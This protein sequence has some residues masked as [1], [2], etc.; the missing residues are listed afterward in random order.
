MIDEDYEDE[1]PVYHQRTVTGGVQ[2]WRKIKVGMRAVFKDDRHWVRHKLFRTLTDAEQY[3]EL[4][5]N[6]KFGSRYQYH[7]GGEAPRED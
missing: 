3:V 5:S 1:V 2:V 4:V 7:I 6:E